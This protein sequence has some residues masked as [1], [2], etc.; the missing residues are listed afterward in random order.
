MINENIAE[1]RL[2]T[3]S[4]G[5]ASGAGAVL[6]KMQS[7]AGDFAIT[8]VGCVGCCYAE[9]LAEVITKDGRSIFYGNLTADEKCL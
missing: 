2:G 5:I 6:E 8:E 9:P 4:C 1:I 3:A 7:M